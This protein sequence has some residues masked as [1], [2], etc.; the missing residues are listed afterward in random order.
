[1]RPAPIFDTNIFGHVQDGSIPQSDWHYLFRHR[2]GRGWPLSAVT[3]LE[4]LGGVDDVPSEK[5]LQLKE[6]VELA[7]KLS[8]GRILEEPRFLLCK[9]TSLERKSCV[10]LS[11]VE[12]DSPAARQ[13]TRKWASSGFTR[14]TAE[15]ETQTLTYFP[16]GGCAA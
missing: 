1:M 4:L 3:A 12:A 11:G 8:N 5:F 10:R 14:R 7:Y 9:V 13:R 15:S 16:W 6:Q 2:P